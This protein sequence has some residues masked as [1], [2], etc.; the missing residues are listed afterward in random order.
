MQ[1][2]REKYSEQAAKKVE[3]KLGACAERASPVCP[4]QR[5]LLEKSG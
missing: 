4:V 2:P 1:Q 5:F 3:L